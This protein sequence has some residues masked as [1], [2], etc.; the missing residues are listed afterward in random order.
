MTVRRVAH[1]LAVAAVPVF[2]VACGGSD[3]SGPSTTQ[4]NV[5][6]GTAFATIPPP[7]T[8]TTVPG[9]GPS[10]TAGQQTYTIVEGDTS[11]QKVADR[12]GVTVAALDAANAGTAGYNQFYV[13]LAIII[14]AGGTGGSAAPASTAPGGTATTAPGSSS[15]SGTTTAT[16]TGGATTAPGSTTAGGQCPGKY[17]ITAEDTSRIKVAQKFGI[18]VEALDAANSATSGYNAFYPGLEIV[19]PC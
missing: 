15:G 9:G 10:T 19:I 13:G 11:R 17:K 6:P 14:P 1:L 16:T 5:T 7:T 8:A 2:I 12:F 18:T 3:S 4:V